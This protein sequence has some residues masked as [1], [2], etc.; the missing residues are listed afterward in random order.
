MATSTYLSNPAVLIGAVDI[1]VDAS[2]SF[3]GCKI[4]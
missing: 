4:R 3:D 2:L 1:T